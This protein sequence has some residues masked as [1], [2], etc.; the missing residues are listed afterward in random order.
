MRLKPRFWNTLSPF[1]HLTG[2]NQAGVAEGAVTS[3]G[4]E[5][6]R[7][8][9]WPTA[10]S[11]ISRTFSGSHAN[12]ACANEGS[13]ACARTPKPAPLATRAEVVKCACDPGGWRLIYQ[14]RTLTSWTM[15]CSQPIATTCPAPSPD[16][17][18]TRRASRRARLPGLT[19]MNGW[20]AITTKVGGTTRRLASAASPGGYTFKGRDWTEQEG[21]W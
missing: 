6:R 17:D 12:C 5:L 3:M 8:T 14:P 20:K 19:P 4:S 9:S 21:G 16:R 10:S 1:E 18:W 7:D 15:A 11:H 2:T 13:S